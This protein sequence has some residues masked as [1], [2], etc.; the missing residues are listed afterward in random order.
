MVFKK[1]RKKKKVDFP[2]VSVNV[3]KT[4]IITGAHFSWYSFI[5]NKS[6]FKAIILDF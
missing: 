2:K 3:T 1:N 5:R 4:P 6:C